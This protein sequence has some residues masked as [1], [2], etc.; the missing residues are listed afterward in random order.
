M[1]TTKRPIVLTL[2]LLVVAGLKADKR[3]SSLEAVAPG[4][5]NLFDRHVQV[6]KLA[7]D[8]GFTEGPVWDPA[9][10]L[11][12]SDESTNKILKVDTRTG[13]KQEMIALGD[14]DGNTYDRHHGCRSLSGQASEQPQ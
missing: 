2:V 8:F 5:W 1:M 11:W 6:T 7:G 4:F 13:Q 14:P 12:V 3:T 10:Y 9:G